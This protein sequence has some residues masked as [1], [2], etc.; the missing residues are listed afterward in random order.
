ML[1]NVVNT[2]WE[3]LLIILILVVATLGITVIIATISAIID[4]FKK[5]KIKDRELQRLEEE[6]IK[7]LHSIEEESKKETKKKTTTRKKIDK[8]DKE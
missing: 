6:F 2:L 7:V 4:M 5:R 1:V 3:C 8:K